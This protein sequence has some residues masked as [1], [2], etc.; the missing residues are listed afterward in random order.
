MVRIL[1]L[2]AVVVITGCG[3]HRDHLLE[4]KGRFAVAETRRDSI[5]IVGKY[6]ACA[7]FVGWQKHK[8]EGQ[9]W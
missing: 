8:Q 6:D 9:G 4:C 5:V 3:P 7:W 2:L 1:A